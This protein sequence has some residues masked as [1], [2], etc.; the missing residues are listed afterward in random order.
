MRADQQHDAKDRRQLAQA[1]P[2]DRAHALGQH[3]GQAA[4]AGRDSA[5]SISAIGLVDAVQRDEAAEARAFL[6]AEQHLIEAAEPGAQ[7]GKRMALAD[8]VDDGLD[9]FGIGAA[10]HALQRLGAD[11]PAPRV[12]DRVGWR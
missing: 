7:F 9:R 11:R 1:R 5:A 6:L 8:L 3:R 4:S 2:A 12:P 10:V